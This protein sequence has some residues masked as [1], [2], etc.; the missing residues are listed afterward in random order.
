MKQTFADPLERIVADIEAVRAWE[1]GEVWHG[2]WGG[3]LRQLIGA[4]R[5]AFLVERFGL[6]DVQALRGAYL[7]AAVPPPL[8]L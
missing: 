6:L 7:S 8:S 1:D 3:V 4:E 5:D 2:D